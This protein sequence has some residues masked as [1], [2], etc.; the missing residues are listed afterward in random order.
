MRNLVVTD[1]ARS[2]LRDIRRVTNDRYGRDA[3]DAY[4]ALLSQALRDI[5]ADPFRPGTKARP[6]I[7]SDL[8]SY[9]TAHSRRRAA[10]RIKSPRHFVLYF[11]STDDDSVV[12]ERVLH[13][14][15]DLARHV[16]RD[17]SG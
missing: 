7:G 6:E 11:L 16:P 2:D 17:G 4:A 3:A 14:S 5:R 15:R 1:R 10:S 9:H 12:V 13:V 8:R